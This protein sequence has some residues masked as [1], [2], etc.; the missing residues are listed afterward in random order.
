MADEEGGSRDPSVTAPTDATGAMSTRSNGVA[1]E[2]VL[3]HL[4]EQPVAADLFVDL[5][6][7]TWDDVRAAMASPSEPTDALPSGADSAP[8]EPSF[9]TP[10]EFYAEMTQRPDIRKILR[11]LAE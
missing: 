4:A 2:R 8:G 1:M 9:V 7:P 6:E 10:Q 5:P 3:A 11:A